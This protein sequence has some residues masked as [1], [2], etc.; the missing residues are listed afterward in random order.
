MDYAP[1]PYVVKLEEAPPPVDRDYPPHK[2]WMARL[3][4]ELPHEH[5]RRLYHTCYHCGEY[6]DSLHDLDEHEEECSNRTGGPRRG[7]D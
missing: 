5:V 6:K 1:K 3:P 2:P 4:G 7:E